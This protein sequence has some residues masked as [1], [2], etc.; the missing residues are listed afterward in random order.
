MVRDS[1]ICLGVEG[2]ESYDDLAELLDED[3]TDDL[4][5]G[6]AVAGG[7]FFGGV[8]A[9]FVEEGPGLGVEEV[10]DGRIGPVGYDGE[11]EG[12]VFVRDEGQDGWTGHKQGRSHGVV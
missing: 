7:D 12:E 11:G 1:F 3:C 8:D 5:A 9:V 6:D 10:E 4:G 2:N